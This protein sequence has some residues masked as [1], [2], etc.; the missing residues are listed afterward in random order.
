MFQVGF[1]GQ[2]RFL[3][4]MFQTDLDMDMLHVLE[5]VSFWGPKFKIPSVVY[6]LS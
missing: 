3:W 1:N 4:V 6:V 5:I 2:I